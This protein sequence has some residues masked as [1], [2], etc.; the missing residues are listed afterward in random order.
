MKYF[1][2]N[3][4][5]LYQFEFS[6]LVQTSRLNLVYR[7]IS[8]FR[9]KEGAVQ[10]VKPATVLRTTWSNLSL[11]GYMLFSHRETSRVKRTAIVKGSW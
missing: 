10:T 11:S 6:I 1:I 8:V 2:F 3:L 4:F 7:P 9:P 5:Y